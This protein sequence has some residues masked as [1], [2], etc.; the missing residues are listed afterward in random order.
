MRKLILVVAMLMAGLPA[1]SD[2]ALLRNGFSIR[3]DHREALADG[4]TTRLF[5]SADNKSFVDVLTENIAS[6]EKSA[7]EIDIPKPTVISQ[8]LPPKPQTL[9]DIVHAASDKHLMDEDLI[10]SVIR[11]ES[12]FNPKAVSR[13]GAQGLMQLM[14]STARN[15]GVSNPFDSAENVAAGTKYLHELLVQYNFDLAK[16]LAAYNA[17][18]A[19]VAQYKGVPPYFETHAYVARIIK[20]FNRKKLAAAAEHSASPKKIAKPL[21]KA[22]HSKI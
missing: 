14:P 17:G 2:D 15:L 10:H 11:A 1:L 12:G 8:P 3:H 6:V 21:S 18:P 20:D 4:I 9:A 13:K 5:I 22:P 7:P 19:R 16:A